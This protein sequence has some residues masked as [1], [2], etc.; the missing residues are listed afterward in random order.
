[1]LMPGMDC[2]PNG[3]LW[4][5]FANFANFWPFF[6][7]QALDYFG[8]VFRYHLGR[9]LE[10][11]LA[12]LMIAKIATTALKRCYSPS[13]QKQAIAMLHVKEK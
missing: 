4:T 11:N 6:N 10:E 1:M 8:L 12:T 7:R 9:K 3:P 13:F 5:N 2:S